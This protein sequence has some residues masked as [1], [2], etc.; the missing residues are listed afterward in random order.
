MAL[1]RWFVQHELLQLLGSTAHPLLKDKVFAKKKDLSKPVPI[2]SGK[3][4]DPSP[5]LQI[6]HKVTFISRSVSNLLSNITSQLSMWDRLSLRKSKGSASSP[7]P[8]NSSLFSSLS[9]HHHLSNSRN[10]V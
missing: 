6:L 4:K 2:T 7:H 9:V 8:N 3:P 10:H 5:P 1:L